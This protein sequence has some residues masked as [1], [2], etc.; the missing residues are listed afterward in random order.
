MW[1]GLGVLCGPETP[2]ILFPPVVQIRLWVVQYHTVHLATWNDGNLWK[3]VMVTC[4][5]SNGH[6]VSNGQILSTVGVTSVVVKHLP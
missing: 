3:N 1:V 5:I 4:N 2:Q 6:H